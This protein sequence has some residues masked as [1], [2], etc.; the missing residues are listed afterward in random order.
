MNTKIKI[1]AAQFNQ[2]VDKFLADFYPEKSRTGWQKRIKGE[3]VL[4]NKKKVKPDYVLKKNDEIEILP[5]LQSLLV[6]P[7]LRRGDDKISLTSFDKGENSL[8]TR[9]EIE[10]SE[11]EIVY[12]DDDIIVI[13]KPAGVLSER[14]ESSKSSS[15]VD[16]LVKYYPKIK[17]VGEDKQRFGIVHRLDKDTSGVMIV[18][19]NNKSFEFLKSQFKDR[20]VQKTYTALVYGTVEPK[21]GIIDFRIGRSKTRPN[22]QTVIDTKKKLGIK[23]REALTLYKTIKSF[24]GYSL[25][26]A[27]PKTGRMHQ[28][29]VHLK[30]IG[31]PVVG[32][33]KYFFKKYAKIKPVLGR[34]FLHAGKL[35]IKLPNGKVSAFKSKLPEDLERFLDKIS[36]NNRI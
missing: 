35:K 9:G 14:A 21:E 23:S 31:Y 2:R 25:L 13:D 29:R 5:V 24:D 8:I 6:P 26:E 10:I 12:E 22:M 7:C 30:A 33:K 19:K 1:T 27:Y 11:I 15:V 34:Q 28:I 36:G 4:V 16:F 3:E 32:D 18:A 20:K 17:E